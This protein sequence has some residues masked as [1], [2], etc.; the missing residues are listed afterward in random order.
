VDNLKFHSN[1]IAGGYRGLALASAVDCEVVN[2]TFYEC[3]QATLRFL[4]TSSLF[5]ALSG[6]KIQN[7][8]FAFGAASQYINGGIQPADAATFNNNIYYSSVDVNFNGPFW[9]PALDSIKDPQPMIFGSST[10][11]FTDPYTY[12]FSLA[13]GSPAISNGFSLTEPAFDF[14]GGLF[15]TP[16]S[17]GAIE[18]GVN[19]MTAN[20]DE[21]TPEIYPNPVIHFITIKNLKKVSGGIIQIYSVTGE[22][23]YKIDFTKN[24]LTIILDLIRL[25]QGVYFLQIISGN[26]VINH[27]FIKQ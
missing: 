6:N 4:T 10:P 22:H 17:I 16:R 23:I 12:D 18:S 24:E 15:N 26:E 25:K 7:N 20:I 9:D 14:Y 2:N 5:P 27:R 21:M 1:I 3:G 13:P 8:I 11:M 19:T